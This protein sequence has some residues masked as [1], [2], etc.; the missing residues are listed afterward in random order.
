MSVMRDV[1][2]CPA[3]PS[4]RRWLAMGGAAALGMVAGRPMLRAASSSR[5]AQRVLAEGP[6][7]Y[8]RL[9]EA[10]GTAAQ[11][12]SG[13]RHHG[14][15]VGTP[16]LHEPGAIKQDEDTAM[17]LDGSASYVE[18]PDDAGFSIPTSGKGLTVEAW[19]R[20]D[21]LEFPGDTNDP[22]IHW[23]GKG[24]SGQSEWALRFYSSNS[25]RPNR[26]SAYVFNLDGGLGSGAYFEDHLKV[27]EWI[28]VVACYEPY[29]ANARTG[30]MIYK[31]GEFRKGPSQKGSSGTLYSEYKIVPTHG[32]EP[33]RIGANHLKHFFQGGLDEVAIYPR[34]LTSSE[35]RE[36]YRIGAKG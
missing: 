29:R 2:E 11:D 25:T 24:I 19:M 5:Y 28:H 1:R 17:R 21:A 33:L 16:K 12:A 7:G 26:I 32:P 30:V 15:Y 20:P 3:C 6:V 35:I 8:W 9:G 36:H 22:Y 23:M 31:N 34:V 4:R 13:N 14:V 18:I 27:G 10:D